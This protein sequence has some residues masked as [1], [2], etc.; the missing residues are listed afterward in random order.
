MIPYRVAEPRPSAAVDLSDLLARVATL[1]RQGPLVSGSARLPC[2]LQALRGKS[3]A[4]GVRVVEHRYPLGYLLGAQRAKP[5]ELRGG[6]L[7]VSSGR[8]LG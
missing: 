7:F 2:F 6:G 5:S 3:A 1:R 4:P 8:D